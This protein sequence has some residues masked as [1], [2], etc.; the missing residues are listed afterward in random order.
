MPAEHRLAA[1]VV[2]VSLTILVSLAVLRLHRSVRLVR[3]PGFRLAERLVVVVHMWVAGAVLR[4]IGIPALLVL[5]TSSTPVFKGL[6][7]VM[8]FF[9]SSA[10]AAYAAARLPGDCARPARLNNPRDRPA[11]GPSRDRRSSPGPGARHRVGVVCTA[12][13]KHPERNSKTQQC[14]AHF[15]CGEFHLGPQGAAVSRGPRTA[16]SSDDLACNPAGAG[17]R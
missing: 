6:S 2:L 3:L 13:R 4:P 1:A 5:A 11:R 8:V 7:S 14:Q 9:L 10:S 15:P 12:P 16:Q 17:Y